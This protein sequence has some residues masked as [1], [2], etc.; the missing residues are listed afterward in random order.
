MDSRAEETDEQLLARSAAGDEEAFAALYR[1]RQGP[2]YRH[3]LRMTGNPAGAEEVTQEVFL[4]VIRQPESFDSARGTVGSW[5]FGMARKHVLKRMEKDRRSVPLDDTAEEEAAGDT[6]VLEEIV[7][8]EALEG[9]RRALLSLPPRY[10]EAVMLCD[11]EELSYEEAAAAMG[12]AVGTVRSR[13]HR[14]RALLAEKVRAR[15]ECPA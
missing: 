8:E 15:Q 4:A 10:R 14:G 12:C 13:L 9:L 11:L 2:V 7:S 5:L 6:G 3:A 1:R